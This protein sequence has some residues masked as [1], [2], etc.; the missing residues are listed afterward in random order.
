ME[1]FIPIEDLADWCGIEAAVLREWAEFGLFGVCSRGAAEGV[2][3]GELR[4]IGRIVA[5]YRDL[6]VNK[7]GV[8][9]ILAMRDRLAEMGRE[10]D[11]LRR[12]R[13]RRRSE[14]RLRYVEIPRASGLLIDYSEKDE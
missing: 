2:D 4:E 13:E 8:E 9:I 7:E 5:L 3:A 11:A 6:G 1:E 12:E 10:L 14:H